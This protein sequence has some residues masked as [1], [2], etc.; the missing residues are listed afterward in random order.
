MLRIWVLEANSCPRHP[1]ARPPRRPA[2]YLQ[3]PL[4]AVL[5][6][7]L[8]VPQAFGGPVAGV[9]GAGRR[10]SLQ[11]SVGG[12]GG[13]GGGR[14]GRRV[15]LGQHEGV[16]AVAVLYPVVTPAAAPLQRPALGSG[17]AQHRRGTGQGHEAEAESPHGTGVPV[18]P[19]WEGGG[20]SK[21]GVPR[22]GMCWHFP[23]GHDTTLCWD[24]SVGARRRVETLQFRHFLPLS[25]LW[26]PR[27]F[28]ARRPQPSQGER[29]KKKK[30]NK[31]K[32]LFKKQ[33]FY[34]FS[35]LLAHCGEIKFHT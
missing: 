32:N 17:H 16:A 11:Q 7:P 19:G 2:P 4:G 28:I 18:A 8:E 25:R 15:G 14:A 1:A 12:S 9:R 24:G 23:G 26:P 35:L 3:Q 10:V 21:S 34:L 20:N 5:Q 33:Y 30:K 22:P 6:D 27:P 31:G 13:G 29:G